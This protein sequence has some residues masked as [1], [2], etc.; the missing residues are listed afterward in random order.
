MAASVVAMVGSQQVLTAADSL[1]DAL[2][3]WDDPEV[4]ASVTSF[5]EGLDQAIGPANDAFGRP[6]LFAARSDVGAQ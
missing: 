1:R 3:S 6:A 5:K 4:L 2:T